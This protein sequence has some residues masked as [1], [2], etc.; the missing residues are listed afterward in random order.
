LRL[1]KLPHRLRSGN[2]FIIDPTNTC[3]VVE[4]GIEDAAKGNEPEQREKRRIENRGSDKSGP[5]VRLGE[6]GA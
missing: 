5:L 6:Q 4:A 1:T 2:G 3:V